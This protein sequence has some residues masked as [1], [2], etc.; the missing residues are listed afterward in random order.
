[1][2]RPISLGLAGVEAVAALTVSAVRHAGWWL[3]W[4]A[5][6]GPASGSRELGEVKLQPCESS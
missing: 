5:G 4:H 3:E 6:A 1:M 2:L